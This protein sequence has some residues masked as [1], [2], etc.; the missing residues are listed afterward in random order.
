M[1]SQSLYQT[2]R[3]G[4]IRLLTI[5]SQSSYTLESA[6]L[7]DDPH[8]VA[9]SYCW[10]DV[11]DLRNVRVNDY[12]V[13]LRG[14]VYAMLSNLYYKHQ[15]TRLWL[16][17]V[18][19]NQNDL[20]E[21]SEQVPMMWEIYGKAIKVY[22]WLGEADPLIDCVFDVLQEFRDRRRSKMQLFRDI[23]QDKAG[24][25]PE[26]SDLDDDR[27]H[28][29]F[30]WLR[31]LYVRPYWRRVWIVQELVL[32]KVAVV[33]CGDKSIDFDD[34]YGLSLDWGSFEQGFETLAYQKLKPHT[35]GWNT[36]QAI[37]GH[38]RRREVVGWDMGGEASCPVDIEMSERGDVAMLDEVIGIYAQHHE[39][40][41]PI[42]KI[43]GFR[44]LVPQWKENLVVDYKRSDLEVFLDVAKLDLFEPKKHGGLHVA[45][46][47]WSAM[48]LGDREKFN[49]CL[50]QSFPEIYRGMNH[51]FEIKTHN[52][53]QD[54]LML[55]D[56]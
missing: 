10:G 51:G 17:M 23:Y 44:E 29:E 11:K 21:K 37:R 34:I 31:P 8:Y 38:R 30:N 36:I 46:R 33:C 16:D 6:N 25:L 9:V 1:L 40:K 52:Y 2:L 4:E 47:L 20:D 53:V 18:C 24:A 27:L 39:C 55:P 22:A 28:E 19:I 32:A 49:D 41:F 26:Q 35:K 54:E 5:H 48:G 50:R 42:D 7:K 43:Y 56:Y 3:G 15:V 12:E 14:H 13:Q 45:F